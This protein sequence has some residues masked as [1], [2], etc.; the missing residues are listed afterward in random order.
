[1]E[2]DLGSYFAELTRLK[3]VNPKPDRRMLEI[4]L[5]SLYDDELATLERA[6]AIN[7]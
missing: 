1:M 2:P 6:T 7:I 4:C 5:Q 3:S